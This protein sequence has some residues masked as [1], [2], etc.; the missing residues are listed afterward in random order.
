MAKNKITCLLLACALLTA[1]DDNDTPADDSKAYPAIIMAEAFGYEA[2]GTGTTWSKGETIGVYMLKSGTDEIV[3]PYSN[4]RYYANSFDNQ[5]YFLPGNNDSIPYFPRT[6]E[7]MDIAAYYPQATALADSLVAINLIENYAYASQLLYSRVS[8]LSK[9]QRKAELPLRPAL[10]MLTFK[11][12]VGYGMTEAD[13]KGL[14]VTL[15]GLPVSGYFNAITGKIH[16]RDVTT[17]QDIKFTATETKAKAATRALT[18]VSTRADGDKEDEKE[19]DGVFII[20]R[21][22]VLPSSTTKGYMVTIELPAV[23][24]VYIYDIPEGGTGDFEGS[25]EYIFDGQINNEDMIVSVQSSPI[26][27]WGQGGSISGDGEENKQ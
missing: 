26:I 15:K 18:R 16:F 5:D 13:L 23:E 8:G 17:G 9:D 2:D 27:N 12:K 1:C 3:A 14:I 20:A 25:Q 11:F 6:G 21:G 4:L 22:M 19:E 24:K 7:K 10:T